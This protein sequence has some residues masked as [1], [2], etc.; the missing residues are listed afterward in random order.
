MT[1]AQTLQHFGSQ[2]VIAAVLGC[3][4]PSVCEWV[5]AGRVPEGRQYQLELATCGALKADLPAD[6]RESILFNG[7]DDK[8][9]TD[10]RHRRL[11]AGMPLAQVTKGLVPLQQRTALLVLVG[12]GPQEQLWA[13]HRVEAPGGHTASSAAG[14]AGAMGLAESFAVAFAV[15]RSGLSATLGRAIAWCRARSRRREKADRRPS[16]KEAFR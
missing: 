11:M 13:L 5:A 14:P 1:P 16:R 2:T 9:P 4:R 3:K 8:E 7:L 6:R 10:E 12:R 15:A